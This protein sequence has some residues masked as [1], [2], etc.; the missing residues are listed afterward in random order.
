MIRAGR[1]DFRFLSDAAPYAIAIAYTAIV[2]GH[3]IPALRQDWAWPTSPAAF[4]SSF[5][6]ST[7]GW[8][9]RGIGGPNL[10]L[11]DY[12]VGSVLAL[13]GRAIGPLPALCVLLFSIGV[14]C[15]LGA[16]SL[17]REVGARPLAA[18]G[19]S[20]FA[21][22]NPW[23]YTETVAGHTYMLL[24]LGALIGLCAEL[25]RAK[26]RAL[27]AS[28]LVALT[29]VQLQFFVIAIAI[30]AVYAVF[31]TTRLPLMTGAIVVLAPLVGIA[32]DFGSY[33]GVPLTLAWE[34]SQST[35]LLSGINLGGYF[36]GYGQQ[37]DPFDRVAMYIIVVL[38]IA[39]VVGGWKTALAKISL[40]VLVL[41]VSIAAGL[42]GWLSTPIAWAFV[43]LPGAGLYR[44]L[45]DVLG[46]AVIAYIAGSALAA[47]RWPLAG[48]AIAATGVAFAVAWTVFSPWS[49]WVPAASI[50]SISPAGA[51]E[52]RY[53]L[54]PAFQPLTLSGRGSGL[55]PDAYLRDG[56]APLN[57]QA[58]QY[59]VDV[60]LARYAF[61]R[62][63]RSLAALGV[64]SIFGRL[65]LRSDDTAR[66]FQLALKPV[67]RA[68]W[69]PKDIFDLRSLAAKVANPQPPV[70]LF[71]LPAVG[72]VVDELGAGAVLF[73]DAAQA[74]GAQVPPSWLGYRAL[75]PVS[76]SGR[77]VD[78]A[79]GW[80][81]ARL[82]FESAPQLGQALG[83]AATMSSQDF[84][85]LRAGVPALVFVE[86]ALRDQDGALISSSTSGY[87]WMILAAS[88]SAVRCDGLCA[89]AAQGYPPAGLPANPQA[90]APIAVTAAE[91]TPWA[92][93]ATIP[94][95][96][97]AMLRLNDAFD[98]G[99]VAQLSGGRLPHVRV[100]TTVNG[101]LLP[102]RSA[103]QQ[104][105]LIH[106]PAAVEAALE[107]V[108]VAWLFAIAILAARNARREAIHGRP[109]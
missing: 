8:D 25:L 21:V 98:R 94:A 15:A 35:P 85:Q 105:L 16:G 95:G 2:V 67:E 54:F 99:W 63:D 66:A 78:A 77:Y 79:L 68:R 24:A 43:H 90:A 97:Q 46:V 56:N 51:A 27:A 10:H 26:P 69:L 62:D 38:C 91:V 30:A 76:A 72:T 108:G 12:L 44:E 100:D 34:R 80:V 104:V 1:V 55:D 83:G 5:I 29:L 9:P 57:V 45:F 11:N 102:S 84:L 31:G 50:P 92:I 93:R 33:Q 42:D 41:S 22:F 36:A 37:V 53:A 59:P 64:A 101:W 58:P 87:Q 61:D 82:A 49:W 65:W 47:A 106:W 14:A 48:A 28:L 7:S 17:A 70:A 60:A 18:A 19:A 6:T 109:A 3:G 52:Y 4:A 86:G 74:R 88:T 40:I 89:I 39:G 96:P 107:I 81:D 75:V 20:L 73:S 71:P 103:A 32:A 13:L 23:S